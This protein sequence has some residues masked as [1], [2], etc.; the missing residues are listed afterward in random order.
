MI[1]RVYIDN[2]QCFSNFEVLA[3]RVN[4]LVGGNG[5]GKSTFVDVVHSI[6]TLVALGGAVDSLFNSRTRTRWDSRLTQKFELEVAGNGGVYEYILELSHDPTLEAVSL[7]REIVKYDSRI[8][9]RY[10]NGQVQLHNNEGKL[11][12]QFHLRGVRSFLPQLEPRPENILLTWFLIYMRGVWLL[13]LDPS[14]INPESGFEAISL[15]V[16]GSNFASWYRHLSQ[17]RPE[18]LDKLFDR[19]RQVIPGFHILKSVRTG[20]GGQRRGLVAAFTFGDTKEKYEI[21][22]D[23]LSDGERAI[24][25]LYCILMDSEGEPKTLLLDEPENFI[26][27]QVIQPWL[28]ELADALRDAG[29]M[30][31]IS[32]HPEA[33]DYMAADHTLLFERPDG[34]PTRVRTA[35]FNREEGLKASE[36]LARGLVND[37]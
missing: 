34:G 10:E 33:I 16:D 21:E 17:E 31:L 24:I 2:Y 11:G 22:F 15:N 14:S 36:L 29:Q 32:H 4:L 8:L 27:L 9:F 13:K 1:K 37:E 18:D 6:V 35:P 23:D 20:V 7:K 25:V 3:D 5:S 26:G 28:V 19:L 30:F 12:A